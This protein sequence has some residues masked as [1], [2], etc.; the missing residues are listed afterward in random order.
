[1][2][3]QDQ[4]RSLKTS[5]DVGL[6]AQVCSTIKQRC[7]GVATSLDQLFNEELYAAMKSLYEKRQSPWISAAYLDWLVATGVWKGKFVDKDV[8]WDTPAP[9]M[10]AAPGS[11]EFFNYWLERNIQANY[12]PTGTENSRTKHEDHILVVTRM[13]NPHLPFMSKLG[14]GETESEVER[15]QVDALLDTAS[16]QPNDL[17]FG[18]RGIYRTGADE[19][20][21]A[22]ALLDAAYQSRYS[23]ITAYDATKAEIRDVKNE[24]YRLDSQNERLRERN[25]SLTG[26][27]EECDQQYCLMEEQRKEA[28]ECI[29]DLKMS[30]EEHKRR[31]AALREVYKRL[32]QR[33]RDQMG[34]EAQCILDQMYEG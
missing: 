15:I 26:A 25:A 21:E 28:S 22:C 12:D 2:A 33:C 5:G 8:P 31:E 17:R 11:Q 30:L 32:V 9:S 18:R 23:Y 7:P 14:V 29:E 4:F 3:S 27:L 10:R 34:S 20:S 24:N 6:C 19:A 13:R 16:L 1:M